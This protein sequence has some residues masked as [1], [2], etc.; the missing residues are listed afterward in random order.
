VESDHNQIDYLDADEW[1]DHS[2]PILAQVYPASAWGR[3]PFARSA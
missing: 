3:S 1:N 2:S